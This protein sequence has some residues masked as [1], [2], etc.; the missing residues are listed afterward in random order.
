MIEKHNVKN[1]NV[2]QNFLKYYVDG[3]EN[4]IDRRFS[5]TS[6]VVAAYGV[7]DP[8][9]LPRSDEVDFKAYGDNQIAFLVDH[10]FTDD[11]KKKSWL[12]NGRD[13]SIMFM[14]YSS[15]IC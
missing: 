6:A 1:T 7:F 13:S 10:F 11:V 15:Q 3:S 8:T 2:L 4:N 5:D 12:H 14:M 9:T